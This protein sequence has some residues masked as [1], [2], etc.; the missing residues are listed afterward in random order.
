MAALWLQIGWEWKIYRSL[1]P[2]TSAVSTKIDSCCFKCQYLVV[3]S[4]SLPGSG[5]QSEGFLTAPSVLCLVFGPQGLQTP[6]A[7][8]EVVEV[9]EQDEGWPDKR[10]TNSN[11]VRVHSNKETSQSVIY[12]L[13]PDTPICSFDQF[14]KWHE[15]LMSHFEQCTWGWQLTQQMFGHCSLQDEVNNH[16][17]TQMPNITT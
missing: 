3:I 16:L 5:F 14:P 4:G 12:G 6:G 11:G 9:S 13:T 2:A 7:V 17:Y 15:W 10:E 1:K 8:C